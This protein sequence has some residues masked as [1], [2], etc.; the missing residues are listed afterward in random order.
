MAAD[1]EN[2]KG[3][4]SGIKKAIRPRHSK[5]AL[6]KSTTGEIITDKKEQVNGV[7]GEALHTYILV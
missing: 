5:T 2:I 4:Y 1:T 3:V 7:V 6:L